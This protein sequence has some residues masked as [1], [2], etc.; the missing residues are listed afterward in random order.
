MDTARIH[1]TSIIGLG[2]MIYL[3]KRVN[4]N[5]KELEKN[6]QE[7]K[8]FDPV[9]AKAQIDVYKEIYN[10]MDKEDNQGICSKF[11]KFS[12]FLTQS[13]FSKI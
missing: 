7:H 6:T 1:K 5:I 10:M 13:Q 8:V 3:T 2:A 9:K 4:W 11:Y 12:N